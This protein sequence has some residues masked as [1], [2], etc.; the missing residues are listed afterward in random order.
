ML[1]VDGVAKS[2]FQWSDSTLKGHALSWPGMPFIGGTKTDATERVP[3]E[4]GELTFCEFVNVKCQITNESS[5]PSVAGFAPGKRSHSRQVARF[6][7]VGKSEG[8]KVG[9]S[10]SLNPEQLPCG[11]PSPLSILPLCPLCTLWQIFSSLLQTIPPL[12]L[13]VASVA[14]LAC[15]KRSHSRKGRKAGKSE[16]RKVGKPD[17]GFYSLPC[18]ANPHPS[19]FVNPSGQ[20][21]GQAFVPFVANL[22]SS[23]PYHPLCFSVASVAKFPAA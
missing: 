21:G 1:N 3:P 13:S 23:A 4:E 14:G 12:C 20:A 7:R 11:S 8:R 10:E 16:S 5:V 9:R 18:S 6:A 2:R 15:G 19:S 17:P 22:L